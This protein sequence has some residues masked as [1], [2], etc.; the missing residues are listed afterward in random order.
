MAARSALRD[1]CRS[2][3][4]ISATREEESWFVVAEGD[5]EDEEGEDLG[6]IFALRSFSRAASS[7][8]ASET[9]LASKSE[10][11]QN[12]IGLPPPMYQWLI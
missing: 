1:S 7:S 2:W 10:T 4:I 9:N 3:I 12:L 8:S 11:A 5:E 6:S